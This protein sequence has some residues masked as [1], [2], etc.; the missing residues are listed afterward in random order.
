M[1][2]PKDQ[3]LFMEIKGLKFEKTLSQKSVNGSFNFRPGQLK[4]YDEKKNASKILDLCFKIP[5]TLPRQGHRNDK[6]GFERS[7]HKRGVSTIN[8][9]QNSHGHSDTQSD[10]SSI[11]LKPITH[12][13]LKYSQVDSEGRPIDVVS[14]SVVKFHN[15]TTGTRMMNQTHSGGFGA[16]GTKLLPPLLSVT[17]S[18]LPSEKVSA[19]KR[20]SMD[21]HAE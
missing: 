12:I 4:L 17:D 21:T 8:G 16:Q 13:A 15:F 1:M 2:K 11:K 3:G 9:T 6:R 14:E 18:L 19:R 5:P 10:V 20:Q 7:G